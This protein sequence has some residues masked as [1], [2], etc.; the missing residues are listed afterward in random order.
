MAIYDLGTASLAANGEVT[1]VGTTWK[2]PLTLIR[3]GAT[4]VFK[5]EPV[6]IYT[7]SEIISDAKINVY[8]PNSETVPAGTGY[9]IL[10]HDGISVQGLAQDVAETLRY[11]QS[12]ETEISS[13]VDAFGNFDVDDFNSKVNLASSSA[14][15]SMGYRDQSQSYANDSASSASSAQESASNAESSSSSAQAS[16]LN[17]Q[18]SA[19]D[20]QSS[21]SLAQSYAQSMQPSLF[22]TKADNLASVGNV[23]TAR[24]NLKLGGSQDVSFGKVFLSNVISGQYAA[25]FVCSVFGGDYGLQ[26]A[27]PAAISV[28]NTETGRYITLMRV[29]VPGVGNPGG[30]DCIMNAD[31]SSLFR[32]NTGGGSYVFNSNG[33]ATAVNWTST[34]DIR[35]KKRL[36]GIESAT[37][38]LSS[39][40]G[41]TYL[42][43][44]TLNETEETEY[45][46]E[47]GLIAQDVQMVLPE[48]VSD[49]GEGSG[50]D[51]KGVNYAG[52]VA[53]LVN[54][55]NEQVEVI[56]ELRN[57]IDC[58]K[59]IINSK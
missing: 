55:F 49:V 36:A 38:K 52:V 42:K 37:E 17:A 9:A 43:R 57:E 1:G 27:N 2:A 4:I 23:G 30:M 35:L 5:T 21:A 14:Q 3:V 8:N 31:N 45:V 6:Q 20:S 50:V 39:L 40:K 56:R 51:Y 48:A 44:N 29:T 53:L 10:A 11:Y 19:S 13:A 16:A 25:G 26:Y 58:L 15:E 34:S 59:E 24:N 22:L 41:Y 18:T 33:T 46:E 28:N 32:I 47:A 54:G 12:S 7:I